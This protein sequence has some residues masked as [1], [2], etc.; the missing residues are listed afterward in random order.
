MAGFVCIQ[1]LRLMKHYAKVI[2]WGA[3]YAFCL[4]LFGLAAA[5]FANEHRLAVYLGILFSIALVVVVV[6]VVV[7]R[8]KMSISC[9]IIK[10][11]SRWVQM[12]I[13]QPKSYSGESKKERRWSFNFRTVVF[14]SAHFYLPFVEFVFSFAA[15]VIFAN[16]IR[17][18]GNIHGYMRSFQLNNGRFYARLAGLH[19]ANFAGWV[20]TYYF[21]HGVKYMILSGSF[22]T[23]YWTMNKSLVPKNNVQHSLTAVRK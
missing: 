6:L 10:E 5:C 13:E 23:S 3:I 9:E 2:V 8:K 22:A 20:W 18:L 11:A 12:N 14:S 15:L 21:V 16:N 4:I 17:S 19:L 7:Y 1:Y